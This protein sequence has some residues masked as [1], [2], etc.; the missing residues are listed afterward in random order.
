MKLFEV[1]QELSKKIN[2]DLVED[3]M[4]WMRNEPMFYRRVY[5]PAMTEFADK[6]RSGQEFNVKEIL[7]PVINKGITAYTSKY[8]LAPQTDDVFTEEH[9]NQLFDKIYKEEAEQIQ[10]G[11]YQ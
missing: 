2:F 7:M 5:Y 1:D 11:E 3:A 8:K 4:I 10:K 9:R 6:L